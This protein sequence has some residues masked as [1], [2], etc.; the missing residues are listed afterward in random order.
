MNSDAVK[1]IIPK[2]TKEK[3]SLLSRKHERVAQ[4]KRVSSC[5]T[6]DSKEWS[7]KKLGISKE[8]KE[9]SA[10][11]PSPNK[12]LKIRRIN[13]NLPDA[14]KVENL[15]L[16]KSEEEGGSEDSVSNHDET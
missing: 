10:C 5:W 6:E 8:D 13:D 15:M 11:E 12:K 1:K 16:E 3:K 14:A 7:R 2:K 4:E 9:I